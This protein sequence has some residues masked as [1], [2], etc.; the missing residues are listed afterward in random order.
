MLHMQRVRVPSWQKSFHGVSKP[1]SMFVQ[2][3][4]TYFYKLVK[5]IP[6]WVPGADF[7]RFAREGRE[8]SINMKL[9]PFN[10]VKEKVVSMQFPR[11]II[12][13]FY[14]HQLQGT[15]QSC[16]ASDLIEEGRKENNIIEDEDV[17]A[18]VAGILYAGGADTVGYLVCVISMSIL[19]L[20]SVV[21]LH[22]AN[23]FPWHG[24]ES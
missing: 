7:Q 18:N 24:I 23:I 8:M 5:Y 21:R 16:I 19:I 10:A 4:N 2:Y 11:W 3:Y 1:S 9:K 20:T 14:C 6:E 13:L 22:I 15:A 12:S 17:I